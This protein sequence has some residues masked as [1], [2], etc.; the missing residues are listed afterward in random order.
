[1][2]LLPFHYRKLRIGSIVQYRLP[3]SA[4]PAHPE[5]LWRGRVRAIYATPSG[6]MASA[7]LIESLEAGYKGDTEIVYLHH[8]SSLEEDKQI[9]EEELRMYDS[10]L[11]QDPF[12]EE[13]RVKGEV[14]GLQRAILSL[15]KR[16]FPALTE[17]A[18]QRVAQITDLDELDQ[19]HEQIADASDEVFV[20]R[21]LTK[22]AA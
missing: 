9:I 11:E 20:R 12:A 2:V 6:H 13:M 3:L 17:L 10:L 1:M 8:I 22:Q 4:L 18:Q 15:I 5:K 21:V 14:R 19:L 7:V 16:H